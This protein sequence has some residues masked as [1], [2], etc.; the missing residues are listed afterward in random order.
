MTN[1]G[2]AW[3]ALRPDA[4]AFDRIEIVTVP[5]LKMSGLSG[6]EW[7]ISADAVFYRK[8]VE[9][10][11]ESCRNV[12]TACRFLAYWHAKAVDE[13]HGHFAGEDDVCDQEGCTALASVRADIVKDYCEAGHGTEPL[14]RSYRL[15]CE[16]HKY[17]GDCALDDADRNYIF[18]EYA[19]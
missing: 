1:K 17:R 6:D 2:D 14:C 3:R 5:R 16:E 13:G 12:E 10:H 8:G 11:R 15:F 4:Q 9:V 18:S 7:R 19:T